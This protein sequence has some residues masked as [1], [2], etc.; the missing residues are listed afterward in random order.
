MKRKLDGKVGHLVK[1][2]YDKKL[3]YGK[4]EMA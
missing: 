1:K 4:V 2:D 3:K